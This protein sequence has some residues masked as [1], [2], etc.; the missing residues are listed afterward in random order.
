MQSM[1]RGGRCVVFGLWAAF[2]LALGACAATTLPDL[3]DKQLEQYT[4]LQKQARKALAAGNRNF[5][6]AN[7]ME[8]ALAIHGDN[9]GDLYNLACAWARAGRKVE[10]LRSLDRALAAG[11]NDGDWA[12]RDPDLKLL[13]GTPELDAWAEV[14]PS[15]AGV[16]GIKVKE[17][18]E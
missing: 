16:M 14:S 8:K 7:L 13:H 3:S 10:A 2:G 12:K 6:A 1:R 15:R 4:D 17:T 18:F 9:E 5:Q 11:F